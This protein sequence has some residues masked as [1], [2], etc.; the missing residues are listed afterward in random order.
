[1][2]YSNHSHLKLCICI[3]ILVSLTLMMLHNKQFQ[4][5]CSHNKPIFLSHEWWG[6]CAMMALSRLELE[7]WV[8]HMSFHS[9]SQAEKLMVMW[10]WMFSSQ[11]P[12]P[13]EEWKLAVALKDSSLTYIHSS[14]TEQVTCASPKAIEQGRVKKQHTFYKQHNLLP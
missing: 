1:M 2:A 8:V 7:V 6:V 13:Q 12:G 10:V 11:K 3:S 14:W 5:I 4:N 9:K